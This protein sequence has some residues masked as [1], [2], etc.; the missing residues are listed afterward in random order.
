M[1]RIGE[2]F[3]ISRFLSAVALMLSCLL[4]GTRLEEEEEEE[5]K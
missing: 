3:Q 1:S 5:E 2:R 4:L